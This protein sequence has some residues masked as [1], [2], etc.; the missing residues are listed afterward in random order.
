MA[1]AK[2]LQVC[3]VATTM[4]KQL[5][6]L[7]DASINAG[8]EVH[9]ACDD[10]GYIEKLKKQ[11]YTVK[12][13]HFSR[14]INM[15]SNLKTIKQ[16]TKLMRKEKYDIV[17]VH[18]PVASILARIAAK[19][20]KVSNVIYTAHG[21]YFHEEMNKREYSFYYT[22]ERFFAKYATDYLLLQSKEDYE[23]SVQKNFKKIGRIIH[24]GNGVDIVDKF[25]PSKYP[26]EEKKKLSKE[27]DISE[28]DFVITFV[29]RLV[30]EKGFNDL[31]KAFEILQHKI[32]NIKLIIIGEANKSERDQK[33]KDIITSKTEEQS[34][35]F[36]GV[37]SDIPEI[38]SISTVFV[39]PS[40][41]EGLPRSIVE[42][43]AMGKPV[44]ATNIRGCRE[45]VI[46]NQ[47]GYLID[48]R[49]PNEL[50]QKIEKLYDNP[51][52]VRKFGEK[53]RLIAEEYYNENLILDKQINLFT[54]IINEN[55]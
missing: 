31:I 39:L 41:R 17:H 54:K 4:D 37:R 38:L 27:F 26:K 30:E 13:I 25:N 11:S 14:E 45:Q 35:I 19:L 6:P 20:A 33:I 53:A 44:I 52:L 10:D 12:K 7:I 2:I 32:E 8:Y 46:P 49:N 22:L 34:I 1:K 47:T 18:T 42:A 23:L 36:T 48:K 55:K 50:V 24:L 29:G 21:Y 3:S 5:K 9:L 16:L 15:K 40:Y 51:E 28:K 43:M